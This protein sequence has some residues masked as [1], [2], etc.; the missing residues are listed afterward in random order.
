MVNA[1]SMIS[2]YVM[3]VVQT[4]NYLF[5]IE[6]FGEI[7]YLTFSVFEAELVTI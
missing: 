5:G 6:E 4:K 7:Y 2:I 1:F 3:M